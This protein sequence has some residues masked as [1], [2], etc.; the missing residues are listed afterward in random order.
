MAETLAALLLAHV[1]ADFVLQS[2]AMIASKRA[3]TT[4]MLHTALVL[5]TAMATTGQVAHPAILAL[6][7]AH[8]IIDT[9]KTYASTDTLPA[10][11]MDQAAHIATLIA[12]AA[13]VPD[14]WASGGWAQN[15]PPAVTTPLLH[16]MI[17]LAGLIITTRAGGFAVGKL[18]APHAVSFTP[19][20]LP[21]GGKIIGLLERG[22]I[23]LLM[24]IDQPGA[25]GF[26]I[27]AKSVMRFET[28][29]KEQKAAEYVIIGTLAS[30]AWALAVTIAVITLRDALPPL[31]MTTT[32][33]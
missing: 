5:A 12:A 25:I 15:L 27:A 13:L 6:G 28:A 26:L 20:G 3:P 1:L 18:M 8:L 16:A 31:E 22:L 17:L 2:N 23:Y 29:S 7:A 21:E 19:D 10:F 32:K 4:L 9:I 33:P 24:L 14:L 11:L 30:F